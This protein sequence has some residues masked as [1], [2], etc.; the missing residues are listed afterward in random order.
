MGQRQPG[1]SC[2]GVPGPCRGDLWRRDCSHDRVL[3][4]WP[5]PTSSAGHRALPAATLLVVDDEATNRGLLSRRRAQQGYAV[6]TAGDG[7]TALAA[8]AGQPVDPVLL[9]VMAP[10]QSGLD[11]LTA[12]RQD[13]RTRHLPVVMVTARSDGHDIV[14]A[15]ERGAD[16]YVTKPIDFS[17]ALADAG[18]ARD[19]WRR[20]MT[21]GPADAP[22]I[23][24]VRD[25]P[26][27]TGNTPAARVDATAET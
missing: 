3:P 11:V 26:I 24:L 6:R 8:L 25:G 7:P 18:D 21:R 17:V 10:G 13:A 27:A 20:T 15:L 14:A 23:K 4:E 22:R 2:T 5:E 19:R 9:D 12:I 1:S 16:V